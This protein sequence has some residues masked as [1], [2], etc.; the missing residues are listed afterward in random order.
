MDEVELGVD[1]DNKTRA[2]NL[3]ER[4]GFK[5]VRSHQVFER[6]LGPAGGPAIRA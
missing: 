3:Y 2:R 6:P 5:L 4:L 1:D